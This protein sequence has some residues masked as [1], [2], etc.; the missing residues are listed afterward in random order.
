M[1]QIVYIVIAIFGIIAAIYM[2]TPLRHNYIPAITNVAPKY[3]EPT[4]AAT[5]TPTPTAKLTEPPSSVIIPMRAH[6]FQSFNNCGPA[7]LS[8]LLSYAN[9]NISQAELGN[10]LRPYENPQGDN[11]DK[12]VTLAEMAEESKRYNLIPFHRPTGSM[13]LLKILIAN[14]IPVVVRT[15]L[16][17]GE[18]IGHY[19]LVRGYDDSTQEII[20][21]D[22]YE[23]KDLRYKYETFR[24]MWQPFNYEF[25]IAVPPEKEALVQSILGSTVD[26]TDAW[27]QALQVAQ[28]EAQNNPDDMYPVFNQ[29]IAHFHLGNYEKSISLFESVESRLP[30]RMLWYQVEPA[31]AYLKTQQYDK[32]F[33]L[34]D[35]MLINNRAF[36][37]VYKMRGTAY[38]EQ[39]NAELAQT[40][41]EKAKF[42][43][44]SLY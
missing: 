25:L 42:Y 2:M 28:Q 7:S 22:S 24:A 31:D 5:K 14:D 8:M 12:S 21:D 39:G 29:S 32:L 34:T 17:P 15:W 6:A 16:H 19:R 27:E 13:E 3:S 40:E 20:Q 35:K 43:N 26:E 10:N 23:G 33:S 36:S 11:D 44:T 18:D 1:K 9:I 30:S 38:Q 37:E 41:F 4:N